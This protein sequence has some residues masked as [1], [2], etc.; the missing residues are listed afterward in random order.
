MEKNPLLR[1]KYKKEFNEYEQTHSPD[2]ANFKSKRPKSKNSDG[3]DS[4]FGQHG[5]SYTAYQTR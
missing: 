4:D 3:A 2:D 1:E 5:A